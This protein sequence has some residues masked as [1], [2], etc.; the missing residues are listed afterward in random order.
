MIGRLLF[1]IYFV[2]YYQPLTRAGTGRAYM[3]VY[4]HAMLAGGFYKGGN[5]PPQQGD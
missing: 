3:Y 5:Y 1:H 2:V 4:S